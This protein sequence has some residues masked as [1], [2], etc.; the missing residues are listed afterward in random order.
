[1][2]NAKNI[3]DY[4][5]QLSK[6]EWKEKLT[7]E[8]Y[9]VLREGGTESYGEGEF[10]R[11]FPKKVSGCHAYCRCSLFRDFRLFCCSHP[12]Y[13]FMHVL[14]VSLPARVVVTHSTVQNPNLPTMAGMLIPNATTRAIGLMWEYEIIM[15]FVVTIVALI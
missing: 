7:R 15:R 4:P 9:H 1:M 3:K 14:R 13:S 11:Y 10:C 12:L 8:E 5:Y 2:G 6:E